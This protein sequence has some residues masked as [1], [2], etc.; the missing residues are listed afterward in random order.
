MHLSD[1]E[2][3]D[4]DY[5]DAIQIDNRTYFQYYLSLIRTKHPLFFSFWPWFD[6]N[7]QIIK[8]FLFF[9]DFILSFIINALFFN[10]DTIHKIYEEKGSFNFIYNIPQILYS[11]LIN[12]FIDSLIQELALI[13]SNLIKLKHEKDKNNIEIK[14]QKSN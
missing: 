2:L 7:S 13:D 4:L 12:G 8:I 1:S 5:Q 11:S 14:K 3:N 9:F 10:I 6:Y